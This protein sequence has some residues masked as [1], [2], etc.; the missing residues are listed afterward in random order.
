LSRT[1]SRAR[2]TDLRGPSAYHQEA[3]SSSRPRLRVT[4]I[5]PHLPRE[6]LADRTN[7]AILLEKELTWAISIRPGEFM[8]RELCDQWP[9]SLSAIRIMRERESFRE[10]SGLRRGRKGR[11]LEPWC[12]GAGYWTSPANPWSTSVTNVVNHRVPRSSLIS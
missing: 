3:W 5:P 7:T 2:T 10:Q 9:S 1:P 12:S 4:P 6:N 11:V 8:R